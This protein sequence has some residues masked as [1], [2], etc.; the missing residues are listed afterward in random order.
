MQKAAKTS[1]LPLAV[2]LI[3]ATPRLG[4]KIRTIKKNGFVI[5]KGPDSFLAR[6]ESVVRLVKDVGLGDQLVHSG[7]GQ[8]YVLVND[9]LHPIPSGSV[10][11]VPTKILPFI[12]TNLFSITGKIRASAD[13]FCLTIT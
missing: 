12:T 11:G 13:F 5:E 7:A 9:K 10:I 8:R 2:T 4:G 1:Q 6:K 3:E